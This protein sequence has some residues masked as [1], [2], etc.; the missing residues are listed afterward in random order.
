M[1][2]SKTIVAEGDNVSCLCRSENGN[3]PPTA[4]WS[5]NG[6]VIGGYGYLKKILSLKNV[7]KE[8]SGIYACAVR[9]HN[10]EDRKAI[11]IITK[12]EHLYSL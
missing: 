6:N 5:K 9:S 3:P 7:S 12:C 1:N 8:D 4:S 10:L 2:C 11:V